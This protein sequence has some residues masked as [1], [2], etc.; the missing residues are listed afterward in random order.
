ME[1]NEYDLNTSKSYS[2]L[3]NLHNNQ[4][5]NEQ[6]AHSIDL[7]S[8]NDLSQGNKSSF[9]TK[10]LRKQIDQQMYDLISDHSKA[11][12]SQ[13]NKSMKSASKITGTPATVKTL[14]QN[15]NEAL[16]KRLR[17]PNYTTTS[18]DYSNEK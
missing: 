1:E 6:P 3:Q 5:F 17:N 7:D 16:I 15:N 14:H 13:Q 9:T 8:N 10:V 11:N 12:I 2:N 18:E 4:Y